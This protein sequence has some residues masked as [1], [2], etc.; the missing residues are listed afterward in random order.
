MIKEKTIYQLTFLPRLFPAN[1]YLVEEEDSL[2]LIDA[3][4]PYSWKGI[5][6]ASKKIGK[7]ITR[8]LLTHVHEDHVGSL[9]SL[10]KVLPNAL[11]YVSKRDA[12]LMEGDITLD[13]GEPEMPIRGSVPKNLKTRAD[14]F[15][16]DGE[17]IGS[18]LALS[19]S[20]HTPGSMSFLDT[21]NNALIAGDTF[22]TRGG[23]AVVG[24]LRPLFPFPSWA[25]W[26]PVFVLE[27]AKKLREYN[28]T[29][30]ATGHGKMLKNPIA[31]IER[32]IKEAELNLTKSIQERSI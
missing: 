32:T 6:K 26:N 13:I 16:E 5:L 22:Q 20:G 18:L 30:L 3:A 4:L 27:S 9:D 29:L 10:K 28:P 2:T 25:T 7:P 23:I 21:R 8:I 11:V 31:A 15:L 17:H 1:C 24:Q 19:T 14:V 12:R